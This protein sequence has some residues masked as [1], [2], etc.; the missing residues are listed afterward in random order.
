M[1]R[2]S[3]NIVS[4]INVLPENAYPCVC[5][6]GWITIICSWREQNLLKGCNCLL[7]LFLCTV[8]A[9]KNQGHMHAVF[10]TTEDIKH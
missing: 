8:S 7:S 4:H 9:F 1:D 5:W 6:S 10:K 2:I 3:D